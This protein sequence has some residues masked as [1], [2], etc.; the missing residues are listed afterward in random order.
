MTTAAQAKKMVQP[1]LARHPDLALVGRWIYVKPVHHFARAVLIDRTAYADEFEPRWAVVHL[2]EAQRFFPLDWGE[3]LTNE[4]SRRRGLWFMS[5]PDVELALIEAIEQ[6]AL[7]KLRA[8]KT[9]DDYLAYVSRHMF[10]HKLFS[11]PQ[12]KMVV[13]V[14]LGDLDVARALCRKNLEHWSVDRPN[15]DDDDRAENRRLR[16]LCARLAA[17]DRAGLAQLLHEWEVYTV[18]N[19]KIE[20][21]WEPTP[22][23]LELPAAESNAGLMC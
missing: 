4:R 21:L 9:L 10:R 18:R 2:F 20:H 17:D 8:I 19:L 14:A 16:E 15:Y 13:D 3:F 22:F 1:V 23:P 12:C 7:P 5:D 11:W 6:Q